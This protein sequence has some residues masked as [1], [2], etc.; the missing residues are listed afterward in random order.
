M[1]S[2]QVFFCE[3]YVGFYGVSLQKPT[4]LKSSMVSL[5][6]NVEDLFIL[7]KQSLIVGVFFYSFDSGQ[8]V[9]ASGSIFHERS[10]GYSEI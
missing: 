9:L 8:L 7:G 2:T 10:R 1:F 6:K 4:K 3:F 5:L